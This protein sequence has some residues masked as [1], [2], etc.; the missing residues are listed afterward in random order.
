[1]RFPADNRTASGLVRESVDAHDPRSELP[2]AQSSEFRAVN[3]N[4]IPKFA[5]SLV[6]NSQKVVKRFFRDSDKSRKLSYNARARAHPSVAIPLSELYLPNPLRLENSMLQKPRLNS[7]HAL[8]GSKE[9]Q[10]MGR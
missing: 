6:P 5:D 10:K 7:S 8:I 9:L 2:Q 3:S 1:V 4:P